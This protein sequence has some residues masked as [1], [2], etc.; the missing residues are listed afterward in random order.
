MDNLFDLLEAPTRSVDW[1]PPT[2]PRLS[3][4]SEVYLN[5]ETTGLE[6]WEKDRPISLSLAVPD[7]TTWYLPWGHEGGGNL[8]E[9]AVKRW[10]LAELRGK[11]ITNINTRFDVH[12][13]RV[14]GVDFEEMGCEVSDVG[15]YAALLDDHRKKS[16]LDVLA[17]EF[18]GGIDV[19]RLDESRMR[20]YHAGQAAPRS[21]YNVSLVRRLKEVMYPELAAQDLHRV[22]ALEDQVIFVVCEMEKNGT[23]LD[24]ELLDRWEKH[25]AARVSAGLL[26]IAREM[27]FQ[28]NPDSNKDMQRV[29]EKLKLPIETGP[30]GG[31]SF[32]AG[33]IKKHAKTHPII[34][35]IWETGKLIDLRTKYLVKYKNCLDSHG[36]LRYALHQLRTAKEEGEDSQQAGTITGRFSSTELGKGVGKNIQ[37]EMKVSKQ[38]VQ[39]GIDEDDDSHDDEIYLIRKLHVPAP[40]AMWLSADAEQIEYRLFANYAQNKN[41]LQAYEAERIDDPDTW[42]SFHKLTHADFKK[43][44]PDQTYRQQKDLNFAKIY[45]AATIKLAVM[46][47]F[48]TPAEGDYLKMMKLYDHPSLA[49]AKEV[50]RVYNQLMPEVA[51]LLKRASHLARPECGQYCRKGDELHRKYQHQG[52]VRDLI[53]RRQRF[54]DAS[55]IHKALNSVIQPGAASINKTKLVELHKARKDTNL[56]LRFT[57]HD[58]VDGDARTPETAKKVFDILNHQSFPELKIKIL[59]GV[60]LAKN[61]ADTNK[62]EAEFDGAERVREGM[63][64]TDLWT[65]GERGVRGE[66]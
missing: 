60:G 48:I 63:K 43:Y 13:G 46:L 2:P 33:I 53:G 18:F 17:T 37:Q 34:K 10:A 8:D 47:E 3:D 45:G 30:K 4:V 57:V 29:F 28:V 56:L 1:K 65:I 5:F 59:W 31:P 41:I 23:L 55:R 7:G 66:P 51:P 64:I 15:H 21:Q 62:K 36:V 24:L 27:G 44:K 32:A 12:M 38:R 40:G 22:R 42:I 50:E 49:Q 9:A 14:W 11:R 54:P 19:P 35:T 6:W 16:S 39:W 25:S 20:T 58:E 61:W 52:F 26:A